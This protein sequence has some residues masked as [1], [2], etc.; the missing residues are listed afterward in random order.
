VHL[1]LGEHPQHRPSQ[2][3]E[4]STD[5]LGG[6]EGHAGGLVVFGGEGT[7]AGGK[8]YSSSYEQ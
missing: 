8:G 4:P 3:I 6:R 5:V 1:E 2:F 7:G